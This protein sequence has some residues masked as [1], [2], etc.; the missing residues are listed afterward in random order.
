VECHEFD[1]EIRPG[2]EVRVHIHGVKGAPCLEYV[3][4]FERILGG[5]ADTQLTSE[6]YEPPTQVEIKVDQETQATG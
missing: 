2:G 5:Q 3:K 6:Y 4:L 1:I